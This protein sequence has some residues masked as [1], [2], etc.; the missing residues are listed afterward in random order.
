M[1]TANQCNPAN[2]S[3]GQGDQIP[4]L[5]VLLRNGK[6]VDLAGKSVTFKLL[7]ESGG[8][9][10]DWTAAL[11]AQPTFA[12]TFADGR[13]QAIGHEAR[14]GDQ[15]Q[16]ATNNA[17]PS[18]LAA[19]TRYFARDVSPN[20]LRVGARPSADAVAI[21]GSGAGAHTAKIIGSVTLV[22]PSSVQAGT[23]RLWL[24]LEGDASETFGHPDG[25][26][27]RVI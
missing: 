2:V 11:T 18:P 24:R 21:D 3:I 27:L 17:L 15:V 20:D 7:D 5:F 10:L 8:S 14:N 25:V 4:L 1:T 13:V 26:A 6:P 12:V 22:I 16:F 9:V 19:G 23:Y